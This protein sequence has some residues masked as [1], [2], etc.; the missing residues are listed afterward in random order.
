MAKRKRKKLKATKRELKAKSISAR[1]ML[2]DVNLHCANLT[3]ALRGLADRLDDIR[4]FHL[5]K[6]KPS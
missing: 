6:E 3:A 5:D 1:R 2:A 4:S